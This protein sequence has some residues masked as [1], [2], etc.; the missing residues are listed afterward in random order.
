[1]VAARRLSPGPGAYDLA[2]Y[3]DFH[4]GKKTQE[5]MQSFL[6]TQKKGSLPLYLLSP[7][8]GDSVGKDLGPGKYADTV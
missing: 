4:Q 8:I 5:S 2:K 7:G 3:S 6:S 1:M